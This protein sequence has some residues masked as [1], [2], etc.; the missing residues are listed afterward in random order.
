MDAKQ[1]KKINELEKLTGNTP[2]VKINFEYNGK[3][4]SNYF[5]LEWYNLT[6]SIKDRVAL[7]I[8]KNAYE[9]GQLHK[10]QEIVEVTSGNMGISLTAIGKYLGHKITIFMPSNMSEERKEL[11]KLYGANLIEVDD[12]STAFRESEKYA[13]ENDA[14]LTHQFEN[15]FNE[16][17]HFNQTGKEIFDKLYNKQVGGFIAGVG[18]SGTLSGTG[19]YLKE[20]MNIPV[21]AIEPQSSRILSTGV[22]QGKHKIQG[23]S[24]EIIPKL[25]DKKLVDGIIQV[26]DDDAIA[27]SRK[28]A[29]KFGLGVG[30]SSG[31]NF[32]GS[33]L[34]GI[35]NMISVFPDDNKKY[36]STDLTKIKNTRLADKI[37]LK[38]FEVL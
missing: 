2:L 5:K 14:F 22:S 19:R 4:Y 16:L 30:I 12:F 10:N 9:I 31:A 21:F 15:K 38:D 26:D 27:M 35:D 28:L 1:S 32:V 25:Y 8:I 11:L 17:A 24:D 18:T 29:E 33:V 23:L 7:S 13:I 20:K 6:G 3:P 36:L 37:I 34:T